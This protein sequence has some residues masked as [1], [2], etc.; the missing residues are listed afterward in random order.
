MYGMKMMRG[1]MGKWA[2]R[3]F[4]FAQASLPVADELEALKRYKDRLEFHRRELDAE[5][6]SVEKRIDELSAKA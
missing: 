2:G 4:P 5:L 3:N 6:K 1:G